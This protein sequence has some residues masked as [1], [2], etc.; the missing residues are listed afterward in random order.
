MHKKIENYTKEI[1]NVYLKESLFLYR[2][3]FKRQLDQCLQWQVYRVLAKCT[4]H[5]LLLMYT[6]HFAED[7]YILISDA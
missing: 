5:L 6:V 2:A 1:D 7:I 4:V 3:F